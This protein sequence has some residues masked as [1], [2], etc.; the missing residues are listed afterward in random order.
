[1]NTREVEAPATRGRVGPAP[2][3]RELARE[4]PPRPGGTLAKEA[5]G[6]AGGNDKNIQ[7]IP[8]TN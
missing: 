3:V 1:M 7:N 8:P 5:P 2:V 6:I 4:R